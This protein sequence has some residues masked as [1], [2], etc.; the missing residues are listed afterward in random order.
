MRVPNG[1]KQQ[2]DMME[3]RNKKNSRRFA[4]C[5][6]SL[7]IAVGIVSIRSSWNQDGESGLSQ[8]ER[9]SRSLDKNDHEAELPRGI[10]ELQKRAKEQWRAKISN[11]QL[12]PATKG[13][14]ELTAGEITRAKR[15]FLELFEA[16][17]TIATQ[18]IRESILED[19]TRDPSLT[20]AA[21]K[22]LV[23][24]DFARSA[25]GD[26]QAVARHYS[27]HVLEY[28]A[29]NQ[30]MEP[31]ME[32][33]RLVV[34]ELGNQSEISPGR[35]EDVRSLV[36]VAAELAPEGEAGTALLDEIGY[37]ESQPESL[38]R[39]IRLGVF[40][41]FSKGADFLSAKTS[42]ESLFKGRM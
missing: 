30:K 20:M 36:E 3:M 42:V 12:S 9:G 34:D 18:N 10:D 21:T 8:L 16:R 29:R 5:L 1:Q 4:L 33:T 11:L 31:L 7:V 26:K 37:D 13:E 40:L 27:V 25:F 6:V 17:G 24:P 28:L 19:A 14:G 15:V 22:T 23:S 41:G 39:G 2:E 38:K 35:I 32:T